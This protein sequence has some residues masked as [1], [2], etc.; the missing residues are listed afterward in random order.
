MIERVRAVLVTAANDILTIRR[1]KPGT[2][3]YWILPGGHVEPTDATLEDALQRELREEVAGI[4][5][6]HSLIQIVDDADDRQY[7]FLA[8]ISRWSFAE[9][10]GP[11]FTEPGRGHH[12][13]DLTAFTPAGL[14]SINLRPAAVTRLLDATL[15]GSV[16]PFELPDLRTNPPRHPAP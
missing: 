16:D 13:L 2:P 1:E 7:I 15:S 10:S 5:K 3:I 11:E 8:R 6:V 14:A 4:A 12:D 9:R